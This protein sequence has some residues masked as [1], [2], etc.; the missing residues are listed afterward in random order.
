MKMAA[1]APLRTETMQDRIDELTRLL[2]MGRSFPA[3][4]K[5]SPTEEQMLGMLLTRNIMSREGLF[6]SLYGGRPDC[7]HPDVKIIDVHICHMRRK[8][9]AYDVTIETRRAH[10]Y[11][12]TTEMKVK[13]R[14]LISSMGAQR[15]ANNG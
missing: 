2:G 13:L 9:G 10:G 11:Y 4:L 8:L 3:E 7:D 5:L 1:N 15:G 6:V 14:E 12:L